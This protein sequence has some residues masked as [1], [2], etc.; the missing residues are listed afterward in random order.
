MKKL[1]AIALVL[2]GCSSE[3]G[4]Y[5]WSDEY[6][7]QPDVGR[8][9]PIEGIGEDL[10][11]ETSHLGTDRIRSGS[12]TLAFPR[13]GTEEGATWLGGAVRADRIERLDAN[14]HCG[15]RV[16]LFNTT[17]AGLTVEWR[18]AFLTA[19]GL[20]ANGLRDDWKSIHIEPHGWE[21]VYDSSC[22]RGPVSFELAVRKAATTDEGQP[23][24]R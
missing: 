14:D 3:H 20:R 22:I 19:S 4:A 24:R 9:E 23:D 15:A 16:R 2:A 17:D 10:L 21:T 5:H 18:F 6:A 7:D 11:K 8:I 1:L 13:G 12:K